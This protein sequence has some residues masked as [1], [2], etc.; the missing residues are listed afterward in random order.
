MV[1]VLC[2]M[3]PVCCSVCE[4]DKVVDCGADMVPRRYCNID[5][6]L[7]CSHQ[8]AVHGTT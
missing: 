1:A 7:C 3:L 8:Y 4:Q 5:V 6:G 2:S